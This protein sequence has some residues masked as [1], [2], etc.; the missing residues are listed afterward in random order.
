MKKQKKQT[1][2]RTRDAL[3]GLAFLS[4][5]LI[6]LLV[7]TLI[8]IGYSLVMSISRV[9]FTVNGMELTILGAQWFEEIFTKDANFLPAL[10]DTVEFIAFSTPMILV[11]SV[12]LAL[13]LN[14]VTKGRGFFRALFFFPVVVISGPVMSK[15]IGNDATMLIQA[16]DYGV[17][18][19]IGNLPG[20]IATP[21]QYIFDNVVLILWYSGVQILIILAGLQKINKPIYEAASIDGAS[22]WQIF[23]KITFP[24]LK[25]MILLSGIYTVVDL[26]GMPSNALA[27]LVKNNLTRL[28]APYSYSA[29]I[30]WLYS[31]VEL[32][33]LGITFLL[34]KERK[35][36]HDD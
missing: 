35:E 18:Q 21:L 30:S 34:L 26:A 24:H 1:T 28:D 19:I 23:W 32:V 14:K 9:K 10:L 3:S 36:K 29:A 17:Y 12:I 20:V 31:L 13:L 6:G 2:L 8:P 22:G 16:N 4:P 5:W 11:A 27:K 25:P 7:F 33:L 15:L